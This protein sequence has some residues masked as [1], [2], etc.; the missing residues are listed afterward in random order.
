MDNKIIVIDDDLDFLEI[1]KGH[2]LN[3]GF[4]NIRTEDNSLN[5][6]SLFEKGE[7]FDIALI[8]MTMP[9]INGIELLEIIKKFSPK[10]ECIMVTAVND[11]RTAV[12]CLKKGAYD[13]LVKPI[14]QEDIAFSM[15]RALE[16]KRL[17][18]V[19][20]IEKSQ[21]LPQLLNTKPFKPIL[22]R[23]QKVLRVL[24]E[25][26]L[27]AGSDVP[28]LVTGESGTGKELLAW[29]IHAA[30]PR[31]KF[32]FTPVNMASLTGTLF[33]SEF[34]GHT[35][36]AFTGA[37]NVRVGYLEYT[38]RGT[39]FLDEIGNL[40]IELQGKLLRVLQDGEYHKLGTSSQQKADV[41]FIAATNEDL[42][43]LMANKAFRKD[44][45]YRIRG[46]WLHLPP[47]RERNEDIPLLADKF[48]KDFDSHDQNL[49]IE[50]EAMCLLVE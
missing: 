34:F 47:L 17:L 29:A 26:E 23:S 5:V 12:E 15:K 3:S 32:P 13:Y 7:D 22:T 25:A 30:S 43:K 35:K 19:L 14:F 6:A 38:N 20:D 2:L 40:A 50:K 16:K 37:E 9:G 8:D 11:A 46:G 49:S 10:T 27:H 42:E 48:L 21:T 33:E 24:Q 45:Y 28:L 44:L 31:S 18:D 36:G 4:K 41:R 39:L 1:L